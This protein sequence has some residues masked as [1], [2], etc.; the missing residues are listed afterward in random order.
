VNYTQVVSL[1]PVTRARAVPLEATPLPPVD[2]G[3]GMPT[4]GFRV[5]ALT[6]TPPQSALQRLCHWLGRLLLSL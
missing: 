4:T 5:V 6:G 1:Q 3:V 2:V